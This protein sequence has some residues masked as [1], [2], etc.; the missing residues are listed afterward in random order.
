MKAL[1]MGNQVDY[2]VEVKGPGQVRAAVVVSSQQIIR[3]RIHGL[4]RWF[5]VQQ[6]V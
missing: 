4:V 1:L 3:A 6:M 2:V 5:S